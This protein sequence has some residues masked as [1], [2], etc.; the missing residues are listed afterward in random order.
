MSG[1]GQNQ[2]V[3]DVARRAVTF[4]DDKEAGYALIP[5]ASTTTQPGAAIPSDNYR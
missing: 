1:W 2:Q 4:T 5:H 3:S